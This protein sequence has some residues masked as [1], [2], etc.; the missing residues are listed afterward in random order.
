MDS[1]GFASPG[2]WG[3]FPSLWRGWTENPPRSG[4][5]NCELAAIA[6]DPVMGSADPVCNGG[7][8]RRERIAPIRAMTS[9]ILTLT[10]D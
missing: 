10:P 5:G 2:N 7:S 6:F 8:S 4:S 3:P 9:L 1:F